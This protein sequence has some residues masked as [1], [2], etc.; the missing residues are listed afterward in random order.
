MIFG[1]AGDDT[2][3]IALGADTVDGGA[4]N[5][6]INVVR[7]D[8]DTVITGGSGNDTVNVGSLAPTLTG[9]DVNEIFSFISYDG[10]SGSDTLN[11]DVTAQTVAAAGL[12]TNNRLTGIGLVDSDGILYSALEQVNVFLGSGSD[13]FTIASTHAG[14]TRI[15]TNGGADTVDVK[16]IS[17]A[18]VLNTGAGNDTINVGSLAPSV[19]TGTLNGIGAALTVDGGSQSGGI[20][21]LNLDDTADSIDNT[22]TMTATTIA[23]LGMGGITTYTNFEDLNIR[24]GSGSDVFNIQSTHAGATRTTLVETRGGGGTVNVSSDTG[25]LNEIDGPLTIV[26]DGGSDQINFEDSGDPLD[27]TGVLTSSTLTGFDMVA[28]GITYTGFEDLNILLGKGNDTLD[29]L[30]THAGTNQIDTSGGNDIVNIETIDGVTT[31]ALASGDDTVNVNPNLTAPTTANGIRAVLNLDGNG[32]TDRY[33]INLAGSGSSLINVLDTGLE[34]DGTDLLTIDGTEAVDNFLLRA[35]VVQDGLAFVALINGGGDFERVNYD[36]NINEGLIVNALGGDDVFTSDGNAVTT[37][38]NGGLGDDNFQ[39]GQLFRAARTTDANVDSEDVFATIETTRGFLSDGINLPMTIN[40]D[41]GN[42]EFV[43]FHNKAVLTLFGGDDDDDFVIRA[44][45]LA[46][47]QEDTRERTDLSGDGGA[48]SIQYAVNAPVQIFGGDGFDTVTVIGTEFG[49]DFV[50]TEDGVFGAGLFVQLSGVESLRIDGAE[51]D[52]RFF[53]LST[54]PDLQ[55]VITGGLGAD[56]FNV[57]GD[58]PPVISND[59]LGHSGIITHSVTS[60]DEAYD[61]LSV[62]GISANVADNDE[63]AIVVVESDG[64]TTI[65]ENGLT[66]NYTVALASAPEIGAPV[67][68]TVSAPRPTV[69]EEA[70]GFDTFTVLGPDILGIPSTATPTTIVESA[71]IDATPDPDNGFGD[72]PT[73]FNS[74]G[75]NVI[76]RSA[77]GIAPSSLVGDAGDPRVIL[78]GFIN[79]NDDI[80]V[81]QFDLRAGEQMTLDVDFGKNQGDSVDT[82]LHV[83]NP[84]LNLIAANDDAS[85][86]LG[87][88]GSIHSYDSYLS[89]NAVNRV[90]YSLS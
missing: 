82:Q 41:A 15:D 35:S 78:N 73:T 44:F 9:G 48:D 16:T 7:V 57:A 26:A 66:D 10:Q 76:S 63:P 13:T 17:G 71:D 53:V 42:D 85:T 2:V 45:A 74:S 55:T 67:F 32:G 8:G 39:V 11:V 58:T 22:G 40:G 68:V 6:I 77:F 79:F 89:F 65:S 81:Y 50:I 4:D 87:G 56:T 24:L 23:G 69:E 61:G 30:S 54:N 88:G 3:R 37:T 86:G 1:D 12:L 47:S 52:D 90:S 14:G 19:D 29:V 72:T 36:Q 18:T 38:L 70:L 25:T 27:N 28:Q 5:D 60:S 46:G 43:V 75:F 64:S 59:L 34:A 62:E 51:G 21:Q 80:D 31:V 49:D 83:F 20:D 84:F 33:N